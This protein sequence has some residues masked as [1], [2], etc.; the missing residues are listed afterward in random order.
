MINGLITRY[1][2]F[3]LRWWPGLIALMIVSAIPTYQATVRLFQNIDTDLAKLLPESYP[4]V[5]LIEE[6]RDKL[7]GGARMR[8]VLTGP[9]RE[10][11]YPFMRDL[12]EHLRGVEEIKKVEFEKPGYDFFDEHKM[13][14]V[15]L[16]DLQDIRER[17]DRRIQREKLG[18]LYISFEDD[19]PQTFDELIEKYEEEY[20]TGV[21]SRYYESDKGDVFIIHIE[22]TGISSD[23]AFADSFNRKME[24]TID[25]FHPET[26]HESI[27]VLLGGSIRGRVEEKTSLMRDLK[28]A[29]FVA[30]IGVFILLIVV[31]RSVRPLVLLITPL[32]LGIFYSF[33]IASLF[34]DT[35]NTVTAFMFAIMMG[36]GI[37]F[38][39]HMM[40]RYLQ[41][42]H[43]KRSIEEALHRVLYH[44]GRASL[45]SAI[46][47]ATAFSLLLLVD[48]KGF[49]EFGLIAGIGVMTIFF[50]YWIFFPALVALME[51]FGPVNRLPVEF[52]KQL[53]SWTAFP[54]PKRVFAVVAGLTLISCFFIPFLDF[55][56]D[57]G[58]LRVEYPE[59]TERNQLEE[60][61]S[62]KRPKPAVVILNSEDEARSVKAHIDQV[63]AEPDSLIDHFASL[64]TLVP[65]EQKKKLEVIE[66][67]DV[68]LQDEVIQKL[69]KGE[70]KE[71][72][73]EFQESLDVLPVAMDDV[74]AEVK[75]RFIGN[76]DIP[77]TMGFIFVQEGIEL[78]DG[79]NA[80]QLA[81]EVQLMETPSGT[82]QSSSDAIIFANVLSVMLRETRI[83]IPLAFLGVLLLLVI[84]LKRWREVLAVVVPWISGVLWMAGGMVLFQLKPNFYNVFVPAAVF[85]MGIDY[86][87]HL[88]HRF[89]ERHESAP[90]VIRSAGQAVLVAAL[91]TMIGFSGLAIASHRGLKSMGLLAIIGIASCMICSLTML[92]AGLEIWHRRQ[93]DKS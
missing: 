26:R 28:L 56:Y 7:E 38:G 80:M 47:T 55:E 41:E 15:S 81:D 46:T 40:T 65:E 72:I 53:K 92:P 10:T 66:E 59:A 44:T 82:Y 27:R 85:G 36:L 50:A 90:E 22:T 89:R 63:K 74:P 9:D 29:G 73:D 54:R 88:F 30:G 70:D 4:S 45:T 31:F 48:F 33:G 61:V 67:I 84:D 64:Y 76:V 71:K 19:A 68:M 35:L 60:K 32:A 43:A 1:I 16:E 5:Q 87:V 21:R 58:K 8:L 6:V 86:S 62:Q 23:F 2:R 83:A 14:Y 51:K 49:S 77:G 52:F 3:S 42:R 24:A 78:H 69:V 12:A 93:Q 37:D 11:L 34:I 75:E 39:I 79:R 57:Y 17:L 20:S 18:D 91:T 25:A 13:L